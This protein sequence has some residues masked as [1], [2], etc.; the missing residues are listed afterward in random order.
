[1]KHP[2]IFFVLVFLC[3]PSAPLAA[4]AV[5]KP[6]IVLVMADDQGWGDV[7]YNGHPHLKTPN[8]DG[9]A[10]AGLRF[11]RFYA[12]APVCSPTR[13]SVM[14]GRHPN[15]F[16]CFSWGY[17]LRPQ[18]ITIAEAL[19]TAGYATG[20]FGKWHLGSVQE[21]SAVNPGASGFDEWFSAPNFYGDHPILSR[22][23][24]AVQTEGE[25]SMVTVEAAIEFI[26]KSAKEGRPFLSVVWFGAPHQPHEA[27]ED[28]LALYAD[29]PQPVRRYLAMIT[30]MDR[31]VGR[32]RDELDHLGIRE[33]T[34]LWYC[35]DNGAWRNM[36]SSG[37]FRGRKGTVYEGGLLVPG[38][39]EWPR[40]IPQPRAT[41]MRCSTCDIYPTLLDI[42]G[43]EI[44]QQPVLDGTSLVPLLKGT[45][46]TRDKPMGFWSYPAKGR[47]TPSHVWMS[48]LLAAQKKK[49][50][51]TDPARLAVHSG[52]IDPGVLRGHATWIAGDWKLHRVCT[53]P[54]KPPVFELYDLAAD[55]HET[56]DLA[57]G[58]PARVE[59]MANE[60]EAWMQSVAA[61]SQGADYEAPPETLEE[62]AAWLE[63]A[64]RR[65]I[66]DC[67]REMTNPKID[68]FPPQVGCYYEAFWL[69]DY[70]YMLEGC[71]GAFSERQ[72][73]DACRLF[74]DKTADDG[75]GVDCVGFDGKAIYKPGYG[76]M[77][78]N[79]V[80]DGGPFTVNVAYLTW[81]ETGSP[82]LLSPE[83][84][85]VLEKTLAAVPRNSEN[86]LV[87][88]DPDKEWDRCP[89]G[90]TDTVRKKGDV[91]FC[92]LLYV[93]AARRLAEMCEAA[94][95]AEKAGTY[96]RRADDVAASA[97]RVFWDDATGLYRAATDRCREPDIWGSAFAVFLGVAPEDRARR[98]ASY[99]RDRYDGLVSR[100]Q[101]RHLPPGVY[102][103]DARQKDAYQN[104]AYWG[105][106][107]GWFVFTL[108][109]VDPELAERTA[110]DMVRDFQRRG[111]CEWHYEEAVAISQ[112]YLA[113]GTLPLAGIRAVLERRKR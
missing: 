54:K 25:G 29:Q 53:G 80:A 33:D 107:V 75:S 108:D 23:G 21:W 50:R 91:L 2:A 97:D 34:I 20:H 37:P 89:Y 44:E 76:T 98:I 95:A 65:M 46:E 14:T 60:L 79:P 100:G 68:A 104:G 111:I 83:A 101:L 63:A 41:E 62:A 18:E 5:R 88:I 38:L 15:R 12:A 85:A 49:R 92:S 36:G 56:T 96:R 11:D 90:F 13:G 84:L 16:G 28:D 77:G 74:L 66:R 30:A 35:S 45:V 51:A 17:T 99:F 105:T 8:L 43:I 39:L 94:G 106:P 6:N 113:G 42:T 70:A 69:R 110:I 22:R 52:T 32:L 24:E 58:E 73:L 93:Q 102:W 10:A 78:E 87:R 64:S 4:E 40:E 81:K 103:E 82:E 61:S 27:F 67:R 86:G 59:T 19:R 1:M 57:A 9:M 31:A 3:S 26:R 72:L 48:E 71:A 7:A 109:L 47:S 112:G 55:P